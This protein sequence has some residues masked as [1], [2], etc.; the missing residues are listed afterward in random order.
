MS[1]LLKVS[2]SPS[3]L[4]I[5]VCCPLSYDLLLRFARS[6]SFDEGPGDAYKAKLCCEQPSLVNMHVSIPKPLLCCHSCEALYSFRLRA[7]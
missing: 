6:K 2:G 3:P 7:G 5:Q 1:V 4:T